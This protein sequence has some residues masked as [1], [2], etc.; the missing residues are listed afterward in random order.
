MIETWWR[1]LRHQWLYLHTHDTLQAGTRLIALYVETGEED[2]THRRR[3]NCTRTSASRRSAALTG[4]RVSDKGRT[5]V[6]P[7]TR[8]RPPS[9][10]S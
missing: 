5:S 2:Q 6:R 4:H 1:S 3:R 10:P 8:P 9:R 7:T